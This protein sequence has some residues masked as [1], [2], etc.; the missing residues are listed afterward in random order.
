MILVDTSVWIDF[1]RDDPSWQVEYL[2]ERLGFAEVLIGDLILVELLQGCLTPRE[3]NLARTLT[4]DLRPVN[5]AGHDIAERAARN[6]RAL[7]A[8]G[9]TIRST[10]DTLIATRCI[11]DGLTLLHKD[12]DFDPF[13][14]QLGLVVAQPVH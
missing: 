3:F 10:I 5:I 9:I 8:A 6:F 7:R 14:A 1:V 12:R 4:R 2:D 11:A 13:A